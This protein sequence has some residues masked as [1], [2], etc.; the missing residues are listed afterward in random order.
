MSMNT[1][2]GD[3]AE[4]DMAWRSELRRRA[5]DIESGTVELL[6]VDESHAQLRAELAARCT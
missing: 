3:R 6:E 2:Q 1:V 4:V 5:C